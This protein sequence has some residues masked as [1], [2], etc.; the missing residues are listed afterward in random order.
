MQIRLYRDEGYRRV[1]RALM[2]R[3]Q[4]DHPPP[5]PS[6]HVY[7]GR[8]LRRSLR[9]PLSRTGATDHGER[10][11]GCGVSESGMRA[12]AEYTWPNPAR[13]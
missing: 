7:P 6:R 9:A 10:A 13:H 11:A 8:A 4:A 12:G 1:E 3:R 2:A 5:H